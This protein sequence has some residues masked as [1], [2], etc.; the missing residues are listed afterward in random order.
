MCTHTH[1]LL[2][3]LTYV[4]GKS[5]KYSGS[6]CWGEREATCKE[7]GVI[8][9]FEPAHLKGILWLVHFQVTLREC[10]LI[11]ESSSPFSSGKCT[12]SRHIGLVGGSCF[13]VREYTWAKGKREK[14]PGG[15]HQLRVLLEGFPNRSQR[16]KHS[17]SGAKP[18]NPSFTAFICVTLG[19]LLWL[20]VS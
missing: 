20:S 16:K 17:V 13:V 1:T 7:T 19:K 12:C 15:R 18:K 4:E 8:Y 3:F 14:R 11:L 5:P 9:P 6:Y 10:I 2:S